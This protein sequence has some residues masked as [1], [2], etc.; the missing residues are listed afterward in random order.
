MRLSSAKETCNFKEST[1]RSHPIV[2]QGILN[3]YFKSDL[4]SFYYFTTSH[5]SL[6][7]CKFSMGWLRLVASIKL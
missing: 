5:E 6:S 4:L 7:L 1:N 2:I 3:E